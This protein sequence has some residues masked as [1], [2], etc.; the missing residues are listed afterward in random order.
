MI[1]FVT[2]GSDVTRMTS[3]LPLCWF[4]ISATAMAPAPPGLLTT[5]AGCASTLC[6]VNAWSAER[7][8][9]S[10]PLPGPAPARTV[11]LPLGA[12]WADTASALA[13]ST[14]TARTAPRAMRVED[15]P[16][17]IMLS[18]F[19]GDAGS[20]ASEHSLLAQG[21]DLVGGEPE[22]SAEDGIVV[23]STVRAP[24]HDA[25]GGAR[26]HRDE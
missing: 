21:L 20:S 16:F 2:R 9:V 24:V 15:R 18:S 10:Q 6:A 4:T 14:A 13:T 11:T 8:V 19:C 7:A 12:H 23:R 3:F 25:A 22:Q 1:L 17:L 26:E 5:V